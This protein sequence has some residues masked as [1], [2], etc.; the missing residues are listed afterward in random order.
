MFTNLGVCCTWHA[1]SA[2][3]LWGYKWLWSGAPTPFLAN[4]AL[5]AQPTEYLQWVLAFPA[6]FFELQTQGHFQGQLVSRWLACLVSHAVCRACDACCCASP[7]FWGSD[8]GDQYPFAGGLCWSWQYCLRH[9][10][11]SSSSCPSRCGLLAKLF[12]VL[13]KISLW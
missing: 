2:A 3:G 4:A 1:C 6:K 8:G 7:R 5:F 11:V 9:S 12:R 13:Q 10:T